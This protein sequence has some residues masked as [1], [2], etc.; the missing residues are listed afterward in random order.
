M[1]SIIQSN[2]KEQNDNNCDNSMSQIVSINS[3][4][5]SHLY[6]AKLIIVSAMKGLKCVVSIIQQRWN[7]K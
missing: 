7:K 3:Q 4:Y 6:K 5:V 1:N 2:I